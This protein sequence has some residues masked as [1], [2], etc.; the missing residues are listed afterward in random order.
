LYFCSVL[1]WNAVTVTDFNTRD[2][3]DLVSSYAIMLPTIGAYRLIH[4]YWDQ[5][6]VPFISRSSLVATVDNVTYPALAILNVQALRRESKD[7]LVL[8]QDHSLFLMSGF[9]YYG[10][11]VARDPSNPASP[12]HLVWAGDGFREGDEDVQGVLK[13][14][15]LHQSVGSQV[16]LVSASEIYSVLFNLAPSNLLTSNIL[17]VLRYAMP[18][19]KWN[20]VRRQQLRL[21]MSEGLPKG[22][23]EELDCLWTALFEFL[24]FENPS[25]LSG[26]DIP[27]KHPFNGLIHTGSHSRFMDDVTLADLAVPERQ[28]CA[29]PSS[30]PA[31]SPLAAPVLY[32]LHALGQSFKMDVMRSNELPL[33]LRAVLRLSSRIAPSWS[34]YW[35]RI[36]PDL[37]DAW[38]RIDQG[39][40]GQIFLVAY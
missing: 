5:Q 22:V 4:I 29:A 21:W 11:A 6:Q 2:E 34:D 16:T 8:R 7:L 28:P 31:L 14:D 24:G 38:T 33:L 37:E 17:D 27:L 39:M 36:C 12:L 1:Q 15:V 25:F 13:V 19:D 40:D 32:A 23:A 10:V 35:S 9:E 3:K 20:L 30:N 18:P 26:E